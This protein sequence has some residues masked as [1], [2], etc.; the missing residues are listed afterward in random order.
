MIH[1]YIFIICFTF[2]FFYYRTIFIE[3]HGFQFNNRSI[4]GPE[5]FYFFNLKNIKKNDRPVGKRLL[6]KK[7]LNLYYFIYKK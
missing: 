3:Y 7:I 4:D 6:I 1:H 5:G 2:I